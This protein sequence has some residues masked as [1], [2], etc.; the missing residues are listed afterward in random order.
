MEAFMTIRETAEKWNLTTRRVQKMCSDGQIEGVQRFGNAW[1]VPVDAERPVD[2]RVTTGE[3][4]N[5]RKKTNSKQS[6]V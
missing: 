1:A 5:W 2:G 3:Y 6:S 4:R